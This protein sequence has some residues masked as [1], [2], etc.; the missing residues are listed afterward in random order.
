MSLLITNAGIAASIKAGE[1]GV[2]YKITHIAIGLDGYLPTVGQTALKNEVARKALSRG[3]VPALG[4]LHFEAVFDGNSEFE[5]KE[6]GYYLDDGTLFAVDSRDGEIMSLKRTNTII[7]EAFELN[8]AG[9]AIS[10]ITVEIMGTPYATESVAGIA[11]I[12]TVEGI[13]AGDD[14]TIVTPKK[15]Q[16]KITTNAATK[17]EAELMTSAV[18]W[19]SPIR[20]KDAFLSRLSSSVSSTR[21]DISASS[22][23]LKIAYDLAYSKITQVQGDVRYRKKGDVGSVDDGA[24]RVDN[25]RGM[26]CNPYNTS[27]AQL[28]DGRI[29]VWGTQSNNTSLASFGCGPSGNNISGFQVVPLPQKQWKQYG[30]YGHVGY[31]LATTGELY[32]WGGSS[33]TVISGLPSPYWSNLP[34]LVTTG[35]DEFVVSTFSSTAVDY[36]HIVLIMEDNTFRYFGTNDQGQGQ[37]GNVTPIKTPIPWAPPSGESRST[38]KELVSIG[39]HHNW[40]VWVGN[41]GKHY[42]IGSNVHGQFGN[43]TTVSSNSWVKLDYLDG[44]EIN[45]V[46]GGSLYGGGGASGTS[47]GDCWMLIRVGSYSYFTGHN[48]FGEA[49]SAPTGHNLIPY[50]ES[51]V[52]EL[53]CFGGG[54]PTVF[55]KVNN[56]WYG[57]GHSSEGQGGTR[58]EVSKE[59]NPLLPDGLS[60]FDANIH[61]ATHGHTHSYYSDAF[62]TLDDNGVQRLFTTGANVYGSCGLGYVGSRPISGGALEVFHPFKAKIKDIISNGYAGGAFSLVLLENGE[63]WGSGYGGRYNLTG[64]FCGVLSNAPTNPVFKR[65]F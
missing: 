9:S 43:G 2:S 57:R 56:E 48:G 54:A 8:L 63:L 27:I 32:A 37:T 20:W 10:N 34:K 19:L 13:N 18:K 61:T 7:T 26:K 46:I 64:V 5:G 3:S 1:L 41:N 25:L 58:L 55:K 47:N 40:I 21:E 4:Q 51:D 42:V 39:N 11:K 30:I 33:T 44:E 65:L 52:E 14:F 49:G 24:I 36:F 59:W 35:V 60:H 16:D 23:G 17:I 62:F 53:A 28:K 50:Q 45:Q 12:A 31:A 15:L 29:I 6:I 22:K 38:L